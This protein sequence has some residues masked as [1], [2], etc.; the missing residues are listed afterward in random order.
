MGAGCQEARSILRRFARRFFSFLK[1]LII[2]SA[3]SESSRAITKSPNR[4]RL[5]VTAVGVIGVIRGF[6]SFWISEML[7]HSNGIEVLPI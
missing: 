1:C 4:I 5:M 2:S 3:S 7:S 6:I